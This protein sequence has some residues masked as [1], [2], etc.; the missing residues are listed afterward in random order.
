MAELVTLSGVYTAIVE[1]FNNTDDTINWRNVYDF[2]ASSPPVSGNAFVA[3]LAAFGRGLIW[4]DSTLKSVKV[5]N[6]AKGTHPYPDGEPLFEDVFDYTGTAGDHWSHLH[7]T[8]EPNGGEVCL[9]LD[10]EPSTGGKP[11]R[12]F[13]RGLLG[14][15]DVTSLSGGKWLFAESRDNLQT[16]LGGLAVAAGLNVYLGSGS[17]GIHMCVVRYS[18]K[19]NIVHGSV[20][21]G[22]IVV[23]KP[24]TN[25]QTRKNRK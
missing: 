16:D 17:G 22:A 14:Q 1:F 10:L 7:S 13:C 12:K 18:P 19:T 8:Y 9:R 25:K 5:F 3:A 11:G 23:Q 21:V 4:P 20:P 6:W 24:T 2:V 15:L